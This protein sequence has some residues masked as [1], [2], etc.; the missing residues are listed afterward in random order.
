M[1]NNKQWSWWKGWDDDKEDD[2]PEVSWTTGEDGHQ[3]THSNKQTSFSQYEEEDEELDSAWGWSGK[4]KKKKNSWNSSYFNS[5]AG[6]TNNYF[7][8]GNSNHVAPV[9]TYG[10][11]N[12]S[13]LWNTYKGSIV[14]TEERLELKK[15]FGVKSLERLEP[16]RVGIDAS[17]S[18]SSLVRNGH[19]TFLIVPWSNVGQMS[20]LDNIDTFYDKILS[21]LPL[22]WDSI[23]YIIWSSAMDIFGRKNGSISAENLNL[24]SS[25][26]KS[27]V[28]LDIFRD[29]VKSYFDIGKPSNTHLVPPTYNDLRN[30]FDVKKA[31]DEYV[32]QKISMLSKWQAGS[33]WSKKRG[34]WKPWKDWEE[35]SK[36]IAEWV[37][38]GFG[39][40][41]PLI[42]RDSDLLQ[43]TKHSMKNKFKLQDTVEKEMS[44][45]R[46]KRINRQF[47]TWQSYKPLLSKT[48]LAHQ[49]KKLL[50]ICD[51]SWSMWSCQD[52]A[53]VFIKALVDSNIF[54]IK[55]VIM[56]SDSFVHNYCKDIKEMKWAWYTS[57]WG[58]EWFESLDDNIDINYI[59][60]ADYV[61]I[62]TDLCYSKESEE[63][64]YRLCQKSR[65]HLVLSFEETGTIK[66]L[67][68]RKIS[69]IE[70][71]INAVTTILH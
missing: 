54:D 31:E 20:S 28:T 53:W 37:F 24:I 55:N 59:K 39:V 14:S 21:K 9:R 18:T 34:G 64:L 43:K 56:H 49:K 7:W 46:G 61:I 47:I 19:K 66:W 10:W 48:V 2:T 32:Q 51:S 1:T 30:L 17:G 45:T 6:T 68:V 5:W 50:L 23:D 60:D 40:K 58:W 41:N 67:H 16:T 71:M 13:N 26:C 62:I 29:T 22:K 35:S 12:Y 65:K 63:G 52:T 15:N 27:W 38:H 8:S 33:T 70:N 42:S 69:T 3:S 44:L 11:Y 4:K 25:V 57:R 36:E